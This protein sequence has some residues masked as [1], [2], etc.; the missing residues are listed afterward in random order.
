M[1]LSNPN[2]PLA[3]PS[4]GLAPSLRQAQGWPLRLAQGKLSSGPD[5]ASR[6]SLK[7]IN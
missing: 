5:S 4:A 7:L 2:R 3:P 1:N 6:P